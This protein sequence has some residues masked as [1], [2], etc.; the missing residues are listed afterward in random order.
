MQ[1]VIRLL[2][3]ALAN[4][5][6]AGE[7][8]QRPASV[9]K[10]LMENSI[11][12][13]ADHIELIIG[14]SGKSLIRVV[15]NGK[16]MSE[17]DARMSFERHATSK[18]SQAADLFNIRT[19]GF[20]GEALA[21]IAAVAQ[22]EMKT[23]PRD[24]E[25]GIKIIVEASEVKIHEPCACEEGSSISVKNLFYNV[26]ARRNFLKTDSIEM[27][28]IV[29]EF[30]H[31]AMSYPDKTFILYNED[32]ELYRLLPGKLSQRIIDVL[33]KIYKGQL[34]ACQS[35]TALL[36]LHGYVGIPESSKKT[37][38][39][40]FFF[41]NNRYIKS[42]YLNHAITTAYESLIPEKHT[43]F[44][45]LFF[46][47]DPKHLD[48]NVH[49]TKTEVKFDDERTVYALVRSSVKQA[50]GANNIYPALDF[51]ADVNLMTQFENEANGGSKSRSFPDFSRPK[52]LNR[53]ENWEMLFDENLRSGP[54]GAGHSSLV[55]RE[56]NTSSHDPVTVESKFHTISE[57]EDNK[58]GQVVQVL[59][60]FL[61]S[62]VKSGFMLIDKKAAFERIIYET[63]KEQSDKNKSMTQRCLFP[64]TI[65]LNTSD[66]QLIEDILP[67]L[68]SLG[69][70]IEPFGKNSVVIH[71]IPA[72]IA[73]EN[74]K[75]L[76]EG[77]IEQ[78]KSSK[79]DLELAIR[80]KL[81]RSLAK[82]AAQNQKK[83]MDTKEMEELINRLFVCKNVNYTPDGKSTFKLIDRTIIENFF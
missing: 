76:L 1:D 9:V 6:A 63:I 75:E 34:V 32:D 20:R 47:M 35:E 28:H 26:P 42:N 67:E 38:G 15:D 83:N 11:D 16:G 21:S 77:I 30:Q 74:E 44:Y 46:E 54:T 62:P 72:D 12:A 29:D 59:N 79:N 65:E 3:D 78:Y 49:P 73:N 55:E 10:E 19:M 48:I 5:I 51:T 40:Q 8:V 37:R 7:V 66:F 68:R 57:K 24:Q 82:R 60:E 69:F 71:G 56:M 58:S 64:T 27:K 17:T 52:P 36:K 13:G 14:D 25:L 41:I 23:R 33:G 53:S 31:I 81:I 50:L 4:Q 43:P 80:E 18:I 70:E 45:C 61:I 39:D 22:V 2:P